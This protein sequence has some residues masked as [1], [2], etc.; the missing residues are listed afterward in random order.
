MKGAMGL[1]VFGFIFASNCFAYDIEP[2]DGAIMHQ[3]H[4]Q[5]NQT[6]LKDINDP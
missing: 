1:F 3:R 6:F 4:H 5:D 2:D